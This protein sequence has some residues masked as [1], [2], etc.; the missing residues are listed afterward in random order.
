[1]QARFLQDKYIFN[2]NE[3]A[4][5]NY[6]AIILARIIF[7]PTRE[8]LWLPYKKWLLQRFLQESIL[9][10]NPTR[11]LFL[12]EF[13]CK[14]LQDMYARFLQ[15]C[16]ISCKKCVRL[17]KILQV[18]TRWYLLGF[19]IA[20]QS[21]EILVLK[22]QIEILIN[23]LNIQPPQLSESSDFQN[24]FIKDIFQLVK[25]KKDQ[26]HLRPLLIKFLCATGPLLFLIIIA[27]SNQLKSPVLIKPDKS[28]KDHEIDK[29]LLGVRWSPIIIE[30][31]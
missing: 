3:L 11:N 12:Q 30:R 17:C 24:G 8:P 28:P 14:N 27:N 1:M 31:Y 6:H 26:N 25:F 5:Y 22:H 29:I 4:I 13:F 18:L 2:S 23:K 16:N 19:V 21:K 10:V 7:L 20:K 9:P 15:D